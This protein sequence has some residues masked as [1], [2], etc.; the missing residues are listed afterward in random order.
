[1]SGN[2]G[3]VLTIAFALLVIDDCNSIFW[4]TAFGHS[5]LYGEEADVEGYDRMKAGSI[6]LREND[7]TAGSTMIF[8]LRMA[9]GEV[10]GNH[11]VG[12]GPVGELLFMFEPYLT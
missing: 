11:T 9:K 3:N 4:S 12:E 7:N 5:R 1:M 10:G 6:I 2:V 8:V